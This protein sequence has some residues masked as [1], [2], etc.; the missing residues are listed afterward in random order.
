MI[1]LHNCL[2]EASNIKEKKYCDVLTYVEKNYKFL[3]EHLI[4]LYEKS[5]QDNIHGIR[6][7]ENL[8]A[9]YFYMTQ[10]GEF[11]YKTFMHLYRLQ[12]IRTLQPIKSDIIRKFGLN[13]YFLDVSA[14][15]VELLISIFLK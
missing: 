12:S 10:I 4:K 3:F 11:Y 7:S 15:S 14:E 8:K 5:E 6:Y 1:K 13:K 9:Y 2:K